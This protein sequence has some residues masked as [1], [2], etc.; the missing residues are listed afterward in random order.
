[1]LKIFISSRNNDKIV[2]NGVTGDT[3]TEIRKQIKKQLED[4]KFFDKIFLM[5][6]LMKILAPILQQTVIMNVSKK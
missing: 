4:T 6:E 5:L 1:M 2:I 3:Q